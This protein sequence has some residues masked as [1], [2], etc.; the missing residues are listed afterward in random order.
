M[1]R[2]R[3]GFAP[4][5]PGG[6]GQPSAPTTWGRPSLGWTGQDERGESRGIGRA[7]SPPSGPRKYGPE[8]TKRRGGASSG[9]RPAIRTPAPKGVDFL[10]ALLGA[11][12]PHV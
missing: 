12:P 2:L 6:L 5:R 9:A 3:A 7:K 4:S 1:R 11:P 8:D 10:R